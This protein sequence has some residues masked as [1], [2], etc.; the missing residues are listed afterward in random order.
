M[1]DSLQIRGGNKATMP[2][3]Q[4]REIA[5]CKDEKA[6]YIGT[7]GGNVKLCDADDPDRI[8]ALETTTA[9]HTAQ[10]SGLQTM[11][12]THTAQIGTLETSVEGKLTATPAA[13][14]SELAAQADLAAVIAAYNALL[15]AL[16]A[17]G[18]MSEEGGESG[19]N[20]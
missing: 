11:A 14:Q 5:Y 10:I 16:K 19:Q 18:I 2:V 8:T 20:H 3:L 7:S 1:A 13:A 9:T 6:L 4:I 12:G 17:G 15:A